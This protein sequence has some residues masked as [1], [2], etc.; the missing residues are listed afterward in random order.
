MKYH[1]GELAFIL[2]LFALASA[3]TRYF[4]LLFAVLIA[5]TACCSYRSANFDNMSCILRLLT[6]SVVSWASP[7]STPPLVATTSR[8]SRILEALGA[9]AAGEVAWEEALAFFGSV[10]IVCLGV[11]GC[12]NA[13]NTTCEQ[14]IFI[15]E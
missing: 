2:S 11:T 14:V 13:Y 7:S 3:V 1:V 6:S 12:C 15:E 8:L 10:R 5:S 9:V 4:S